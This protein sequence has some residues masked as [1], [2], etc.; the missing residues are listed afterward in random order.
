MMD[1]CHDWSMGDVWLVAILVSWLSWNAMLR[2]RPP[3]SSCSRCGRMP[4]RIARAWADANL[5]GET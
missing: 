4:Q 1:F 3:S 5:H 2:F